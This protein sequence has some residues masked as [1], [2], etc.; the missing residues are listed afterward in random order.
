MRGTAAVRH[1]RNKRKEELADGSPDETEEWSDTE[2]STSNPKFELMP[3]F[4]TSPYF[5][6]EVRFVR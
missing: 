5:A 6:N 1:A 2:L 4:N 3:S